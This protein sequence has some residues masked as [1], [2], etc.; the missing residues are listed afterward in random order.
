MNMSLNIEQHLKEFILFL[1]ERGIDA[2]EVSANE[3]MM[4]ELMLKF[5]YHQIGFC[6]AVLEAQKHSPTRIKQLLTIN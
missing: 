3:S 5:Y 4:G 1:T 2:K 6:D